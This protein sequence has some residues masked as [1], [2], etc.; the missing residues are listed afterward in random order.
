MIDDDQTRPNSVT[1]EKCKERKD[2]MEYQND[3]SWP[4]GMSSLMP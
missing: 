2:P 4:H 3:R 1:M